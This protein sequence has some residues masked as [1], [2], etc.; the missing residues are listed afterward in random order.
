ML[1]NSFDLQKNS[2][3]SR[4]SQIDNTTSVINCYEPSN[5]AYQVIRQ[6]G[7]TPRLS[8]FSV[9]TGTGPASSDTTQ[10]API[11][12]TYSGVCSRLVLYI[13]SSISNDSKF[14]CHMS[15][16]SKPL[17][18]RAS[19]DDN[20]QKLLEELKPEQRFVNVLFDEVKMRSTLRYS[21]GH[22][23]G[24][25]TNKPD[26]PDT[27]ATSALVIEIIC[28][29]G[30]PRYIFC[31]HPVAKLNAP[32]LKGVLLEAVAAIKSKGGGGGGV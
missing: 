18:S 21:D 2:L 17:L 26:N 15:S 32:E 8:P 23:M 20:L 5:E 11:Y 9:S 28:H 7:R 1:K 10:R 25:A 31:V 12:E 27:L 6:H 14:R 30:G 16:T 4:W 13:S 19:D 22:V 29:H 3:V 24:H